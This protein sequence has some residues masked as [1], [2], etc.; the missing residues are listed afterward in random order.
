[1]SLK[2]QSMIHF[3]TLLFSFEFCVFGCPFTTIVWNI[4]W[5]EVIKFLVKG[6]LFC[7]S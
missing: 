5:V 6:Y 7:I 3:L 1:M 4:R 2:M